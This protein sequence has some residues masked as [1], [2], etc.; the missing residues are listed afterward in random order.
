[1]PEYYPAF[2][3]LRGRKGVVV[4]GGAV[5]LRKVQTLLE[6]G[7]KVTV[8]SPKLSGALEEWAAQGAIQTIRRLYCLGDL[9]GAAIA[10]AAT[11]DPAVNALVAEEARE[12]RVLVNVIDTPELC[13]FIAPSIVR[14]GDIV[15]AVSTEGHSPA[16]AKKLRLELERA[17]PPEY[18]QLADIL[19]E[20][21]AELLQRGARVPPER[22]QESMDGHLLELIRRGEMEQARQ[23]L[24]D[25]LEGN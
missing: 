24:L 22:W 16:L 20:V 8:I 2:L 17:I 19:S 11:D 13:D 3:N 7:A 9:R 12:Q 25:M 6:C 4:G 1:M 5:A 18:A 10:I 23:R 15:I 21:R 14:R